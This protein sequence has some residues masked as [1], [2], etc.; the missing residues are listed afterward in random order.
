MLRKVLTTIFIIFGG[1]FLI[2]ISLISVSS[3]EEISNKINLATLVA[4]PQNYIEIAALE[5]IN[6]LPL[7]DNMDLYQYDDPGPP[8]RPAHTARPY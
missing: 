3:H 1:L 5:D 7:E 4:T 2:I 8:H 6:D